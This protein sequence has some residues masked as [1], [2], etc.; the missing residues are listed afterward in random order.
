MLFS[1]LM[2]K[3]YRARVHARANEL[4]CVFY[5]SHENFE[6]MKRERHEFCSSM[7]HTLSGNFYYYGERRTDRIVVFEHGMGAGHRSYMREIEL[8]A[9]HGYT[10]FSYDHTGCAESGGESTNGFAQSLRDLNDAICEL[11]SIDEYKN[12]EISV[13]GHSWGGFSTLNIGAL[14]PDITHLVAMAGFVSVERILKAS[15]TGFISRFYDRALEIETAANPEFVDFSAE[16]SLKKTEASLLVIHSRDD[17]IVDYNV[18]FAYLEK[19]LADRKNT[20]FLSCEG[21]DHNPSYTEDAVEYKSVFLK[22]LRRKLTRRALKTEKAC[23]DFKSGFDW[24][25]MTAQDEAVWNEIFDF[26]EKKQ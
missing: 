24:Y 21:K 8:I 12:A 5:F 17:S 25:R 20:K 2:E 18:N 6:G 22:S 15:L 26:L 1:K 10:V 19:A 13:I 16:E 9:R 11:K 4:D 3:G 23:E 14:H 7:G